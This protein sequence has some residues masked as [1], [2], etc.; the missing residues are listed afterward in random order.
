MPLTLWETQMR[1]GMSVIRSA[2]GSR[3]EDGKLR[4]LED[5]FGRV[6]NPPN[7]RQ[8]LAKDA[9]YV[10]YDGDDLIR[11]YEFGWFNRMSTEQLQEA[12]LVWTQYAGL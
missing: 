7:P 9:V 2:D 10:A 6:S 8:A 3:L 12:D 11:R 5:Y 4:Q 1:L